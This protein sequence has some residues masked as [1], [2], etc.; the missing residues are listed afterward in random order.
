MNKKTIPEALNQVFTDLKT[1]ID[2]NF[3]SK[4]AVENYLNGN[5]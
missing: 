4:E 3:A 1:W 2:N 5:K